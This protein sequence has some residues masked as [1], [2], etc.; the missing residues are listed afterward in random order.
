MKLC[1]EP[2][3]AVRALE[4]LQSNRCGP[5]S[6]LD[7]D[8][9]YILSQKTP[10]P[11]FF[12]RYAISSWIGWVIGS[13]LVTAILVWLQETDRIPLD[14][15]I[16]IISYIGGLALSSFFFNALG[17]LAAFGKEQVDQ[18]L[19]MGNAVTSFAGDLAAGVTP[20][21]ARELLGATFEMTLFPYDCSGNDIRSVAVSGEQLL[22]L[23]GLTLQ[24][25]VY[26]TTRF[27]TEEGID[28][29]RLPLKYI[30]LRNEVNTFTSVKNRNELSVLMR[31]ATR[32]VAL[33]TEQGILPENRWK[34]SV[35]NT[36][37]FNSA[38]G[39]LPIA[40]SVRVT[41]VSNNFLFA[42]V[43]ITT[44]FIPLAGEFGPFVRIGFGFGVAVILYGALLIRTRESEITN[45]DNPTVGV[46]LKDL[47][48]PIA[49]AVLAE[50]GSIK[51]IGSTVGQASVDDA[52]AP[53]PIMPKGYYDA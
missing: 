47:D 26:G 53:I 40:K 50:I 1:S 14:F 10:T 17:A 35:D 38:I 13:T 41:Q 36:G 22:C 31:M 51:M 9:P 12:Q 3:P 7:G 24:S 28:L 6:F 42:A 49:A 46:F 45:L 15:D 34:K 19:K 8:I 18:Y 48:D 33:I 23:L 20:A 43:A 44:P 39:A 52:L 32:M 4:C 25:A 37:D 2:G 11:G 21:Q 27:L 30:I 16:S 5:D 29:N